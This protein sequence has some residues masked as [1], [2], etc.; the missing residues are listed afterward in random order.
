MKMAAG[1]LSG[2]ATEWKTTVRS[3]N[4]MQEISKFLKAT[5][6]M[7][8]ISVQRPENEGVMPRMAQTFDGVL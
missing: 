8:G 5:G 7:K 2:S 4:G 3:A 1:F 6:P